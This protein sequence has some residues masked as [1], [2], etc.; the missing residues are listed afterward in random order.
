MKYNVSM[1]TLSENTN[2]SDAV[3]NRTQQISGVQ[4]TAYVYDNNDRLTSETGATEYQEKLQKALNMNGFIM[5]C[6]GF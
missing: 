1:V 4:T 3:G 2:R 6:D 5:V